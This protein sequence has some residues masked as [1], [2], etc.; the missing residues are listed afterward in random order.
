MMSEDV[1]MITWASM[2]AC[3]YKSLPHDYK[4]VPCYT[5]DKSKQL[6]DLNRLV[7]KV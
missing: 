7:G 5:Y 6:Y 2:V 1:I 3:E 4:I